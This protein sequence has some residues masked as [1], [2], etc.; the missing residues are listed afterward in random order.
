M[1]AT[2]KEVTST[3][4]RE[5]K[6]QTKA[7]KISLQALKEKRE[8]DAQNKTKTMRKIDYPRGEILFHKT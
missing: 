2:I 8:R 4:E 5:N 1:E 7:F 3:G 6:K